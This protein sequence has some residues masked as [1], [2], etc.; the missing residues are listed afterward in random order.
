MMFVLCLLI[1]PAAL[2]ALD[3]QAV[4]RKERARRK[5]LAAAGAASQRAKFTDRDLER[6]AHRREE[7]ATAVRPSRDSRVANA[8]AE[9]RSA[10]QPKL[11]SRDLEAE[12]EFWRKETEKHR[13]ELARID[14]RIRRLQ[15]RLTQARS[16]QRPG[17][18][19]R[20]DP[21][22][23]LLSESLEALHS[24]RRI[25]EQTFRERARRAGAF[26]GWIR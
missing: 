12:R 13:R 25:L 5:A 23:T 3:L 19:L 1:I 16:R 2:W 6:Y 20:H 24:E 22:L 9:S 15:W 7:S 10:P 11:E 14:A 21:T 4:A 8:V 18:R 26:P 17:G